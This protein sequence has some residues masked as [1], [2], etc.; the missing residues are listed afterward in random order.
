[1]PEGALH[2][3]DEIS[4]RE[5]TCYYSL[6]SGRH[7]SHKKFNF[8]AKTT[9]DKWPSAITECLK[10]TQ[11]VS[12]YHIAITFTLFCT[13]WKFDSIIVSINASV[14]KMSL[15]TYIF[16]IQFNV[17]F[18]WFISV[19]ID[20]FGNLTTSLCPLMQ[21]FIKGVIP[22][23]SK[24][25]K[26]KSFLLISFT[27]LSI[28]NFQFT[29]IFAWHWLVSQIFFMVQLFCCSVLRLLCTGGNTI[30]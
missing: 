25:F 16:I 18:C 21:A 9:E 3:F 1:M 13:Y 28:D 6:H 19:S 17:R 20:N 8:R 24:S 26:S 5:L 23:V 2:Y 7:L 12:F 10:I 4:F 27:G 30:L 29:F 22:H 11:K 15:S 14:H